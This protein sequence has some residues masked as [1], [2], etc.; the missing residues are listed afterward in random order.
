[1]FSPFF[2][3]ENTVF[4]FTERTKV[5]PGVVNMLYRRK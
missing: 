1:M 4:V 2:I 5:R 3:T